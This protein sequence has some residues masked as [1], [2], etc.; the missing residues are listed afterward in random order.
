M[1]LAAS[2]IPSKKGKKTHQ[3]LLLSSELLEIPREIPN[4]KRLGLW[5]E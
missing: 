5:H 3:N 4:E 2:P 1:E